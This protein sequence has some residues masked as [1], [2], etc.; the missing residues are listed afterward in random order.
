MPKDYYIVIFPSTHLAL[1]AER[2]AQEA[3]IPVIMIPVPRHISTDCNMGMRVSS[4]RRDSLRA[5]LSSEGIE[6]TFMLWRK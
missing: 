1:R 6:C 3:G 4:E 2:V 5:L